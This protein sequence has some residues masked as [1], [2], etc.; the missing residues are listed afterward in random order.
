MDEGILY[1]TDPSRYDGK[2]WYIIID[3]RV[4][5]PYDTNIEAVE[6]YNTVM[7]DRFEDL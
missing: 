4:Y 7:E 1:N 6:A 5:G 2:G 3:R